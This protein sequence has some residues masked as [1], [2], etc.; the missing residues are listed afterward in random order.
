[1]AQTYFLIPT[2]IGEAKLANAQ[3]LGV[4]LKL[5]AMAVGD[6]NG[7]LP[8]P[9]RD[10]T[11]LVNEKRRAAINS[12]VQDPTNPSQ[13]IAEQVIP[14]NVGGW[15]IREGGLFDVDGD[16]IYYANIPETYKPVLAEGSARNQIVRLVGAM[17]GGASVELK[18]DPSIVLATRDY[19][20]TQL[21]G[22]LA[23][24][25]AKQ[26]VLVA[27]TAALP[28]LSGL[29]NVDG[30]ALPAGARVL[31]K[32]QAA[33]KDNGIYVAAVG[34]WARAADA[35]AAMEVTPGMLVPVEQGDKNADSLW[36]LATDGVVV[37]G[38]TALS[39]E[40]AAG[41]TGVTGGTYTSVTVD[42]RGRVTGGTNPQASETVAGP[43][44]AA[45][46]AETDDGTNDAKFV[47]PKKLVAW[48]KQ[49]TAT[50]PGMAKIATQ[51]ETDDGTDDTK[52]VTPKKLVAWVKQ[53]TETVLGMAKVATQAITDAGTSD[54]TIVT[55]KKLRNGI[56]YS[57]GQTGYLV[58]PS[59]LGGLVFQWGLWNGI[60]N[61]NTVNVTFPIAYPNAAYVVVATQVSP[62]GAA[63]RIVE[64]VIRG[65]TYFDAWGNSTAN[66]I[67]Y[68]SIG[69]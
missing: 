39:F 51:A 49:A 50:V 60:N 44:M 12:I 34:G 17:T 47:T 27:T 38:V 18:V 35:D 9:S 53:A 36:Q 55:P 37:I 19:V 26:S 40:M 68:I 2:A 23:K 11:A 28:A 14:E 61:G 3:A 64:A 65:T 43:A 41:K 22:E 8:V 1:M 20:D 31:V 4:A 62:T 16:L 25:D 46:Q 52:F 6:G 58:F 24:R 15:W 42:V 30:V 5:T 69:R 32:D 56:L 10:R 54:A 57:F 59:W 45:T 67:Y 21:A 7:A 63:S 29:L 33:G 48:T 13:F 66:A